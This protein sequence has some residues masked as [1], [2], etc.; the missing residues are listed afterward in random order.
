MFGTLDVHGEGWL[1][2]LLP[3][4]NFSFIFSFVTL[5]SSQSVD[6]IHMNSR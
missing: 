4:L 3:G 5:L 1:L 6:I 2:E